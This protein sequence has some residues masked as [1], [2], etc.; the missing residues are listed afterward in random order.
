ML[1]AIYYLSAKALFV[2]IDCIGHL[3]SWLILSCLFCS[4]FQ[5]GIDENWAAAL[6]HNPEAFARVVCM[7]VL[8]LYFNARSFFCLL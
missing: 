1:C 5:K 3:S 2:I 6:E 7:I 4:I 8:Q